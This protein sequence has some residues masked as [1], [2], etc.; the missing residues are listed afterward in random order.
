[1][2]IKKRSILANTV[3][4]AAIALG[5][6]L[7][8]FL[9]ESVI[10]YTFGAGMETDAFYMAHGMSETVLS[11]IVSLFAVAFLPIFTEIK[12]NEG[13]RRA[14]DYAS[15]I[16][17]TIAVLA[18]AV[19][20]VAFVFAPQIMEIFSGGFEGEKMV[21]T[22][23]LVR[24]FLS[25]AC[26]ITVSRYLLSIH[27]ANESFTIPQLMGVPLNIFNIVACLTIC[28]YWGISALVWAIAASYLLQLFI[29]WVTIRK[30]YHYRPVLN[31]K[32]K[33][34]RTTVLVGLPSV[35]ASVVGTIDMTVDRALASGLP[36]GSVAALSYSSTLVGF[37]AAL[38]IT[39]LVTVLFTRLSEQSA[40]RD[41]AGIVS[42][43]N[44]GITFIMAVAIPITVITFINAADIVK[45]VYARGEFD[46]VAVNYT[47][48]PLR[49]YILGTFFGGVSMLLNRALISLKKTISLMVCGIAGTALNIVLNLIL[50]RV[51]GIGGLA[52]ATSI[53]SVFIA[54]M[55]LIIVRRVVGPLG[56]QSLLVQFLKIATSS[57]IC[58]VLV[59]LALQYMPF[60]RPIF[61][62]TCCAA[63][64]LGSYAVT[65]L[66]LRAEAAVEGLAILTGFIK[67]HTK[68]LKGE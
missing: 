11:I 7:I 41:N 53:S 64:G 22:V 42:S 1:M 46:A 47:T 16:I 36:E 26:F 39:P 33:F 20:S 31:I 68:Q 32:D 17:N 19:S 10:A 59:Y 34:L 37:A 56:L 29:L 58:G 49:Y 21:L 27:N 43:L 14:D 15:N 60:I 4:I 9:R 30:T 44:K 2:P 57:A 24:I 8:G 18:L 38:F 6:K 52:L 67:K 51:M 28:R 62:F 65:M 66:I 54:G 3:I 35:A 63:I 61:R 12:V 40:N 13:A 48:I 55:Q 45:T 50:V 25:F 5:S 23:R